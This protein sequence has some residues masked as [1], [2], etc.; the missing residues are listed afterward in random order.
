MH[1]PGHVLMK[2]D[3]FKVRTTPHR[4]HTTSQTLQF[5][6]HVQ[7]GGVYCPE[8]AHL[9]SDR[10]S[11]QIFEHEKSRQ[12]ILE[13]IESLR[14]FWSRCDAFVIE[15]SALRE[16]HGDLDGRKVIVNNF[17][18][19]DQEKHK[20]RVALEAERGVSLPVIPIG[21]ET[22]SAS[23]AHASMAAIKSVLK[24]PIIWVCHQ[25]PPSDD[26]KYEVVNKVRLHLANTIKSGAEALGDA[27]FDP[28]TV[29][30]EI[31]QEVF[32]QNRGEDLDHMTPEA[33][34]V[35]AGRY[36]TIL[37]EVAALKTS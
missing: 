16:H 31:G 28:S 11:A 15:I 4:L 33:A 22:S 5:A 36:G 27:F 21:F 7:N 35:L 23:Q 3:G 25:R 26:P 6:N 24:K 30:A 32:F 37:R 8:M 19:R 20:D 10:A 29:A 13:E 17:S 18:A 1:D 12:A 9:I 2:Q 14:D 34:E